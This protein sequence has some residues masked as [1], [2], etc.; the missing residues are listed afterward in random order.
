MP[1]A[2]SW[3]D[4]GERDRAYEWMERAFVRGMSPGYFATR[5]ALRELMADDRYRRHSETVPASGGE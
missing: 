1:I 3:D 5:A 4:L 2:H